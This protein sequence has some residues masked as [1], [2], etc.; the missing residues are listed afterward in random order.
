MDPILIIVLVIFLVLVLLAVTTRNRS[1]GTNGQPASDPN[2]TTYDFDVDT[3]G[4]IPTVGRR[5]RIQAPGQ[6]VNGAMR[7]LDI[8]AMPLPRVGE[9]TL[10]PE[11]GI[12]SLDILV[13]NPS[14]R[15]AGTNQELYVFDP[16]LTVSVE[17]TPEDMQ[18]S[19]T[20]ISL[21]RTRSIITGYESES[22]W[23]FERLPTT[24]SANNATG[25]VTLTAQVNTLNPKDPMWAGRP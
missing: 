8:T 5:V 18:Y 23:R 12:Q 11:K 14:A 19:Q 2:A 4:V 7:K 6:N 15:I 9:L 1:N 10:P 16:P 24:M 17:L 25:G 13:L 21:P 20:E 22:G 3:E